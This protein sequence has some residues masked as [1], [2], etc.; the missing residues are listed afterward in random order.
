MRRLQ[1]EGV[2]VTNTAA[3]K[4]DSCGG[5][6]EN[7]IGKVCSKSVHRARASLS[8]CKHRAAGIW[9]TRLVEAPASFTI[10]ACSKGHQIRVP[11]DLAA[12]HISCPKCLE[13]IQWRTPVAPSRFAV[14]RKK[15]SLKSVTVTTIVSIIILLVVC[16]VGQAWLYP[17]DNLTITADT[18]AARALPPVPENDLPVVRAVPRDD[19]APGF[20][21]KA[22][23]NDVPA[24]RAI[25]PVPDNTINAGPPRPTVLEK[26][27]DPPVFKQPAIAMPANGD[28]VPWFQGNPDPSLKITTPDDG[29]RYIKIETWRTGEVVA[30][31]FIRSGRTGT[32]N[33]PPGTYQIKVAKGGDHWFGPM[34]LFGTE[35]ECSVLNDWFEFTETEDKDGTTHSTIWEVT[36]IKQVNGNLKSKPI[37]ITD[38]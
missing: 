7:T 29:N 16:L 32:V 1:T 2:F 17:K 37:P 11:S 38:F 10:I 23:N 35:T 28:V 8:S 30:T 33:L 24:A 18:P 20:I 36:L 21:P 34:Y 25:Q 26:K 9:E 19:S 3:V 22:S 4:C 12:L 31:I 14:W 5:W 6:I 15:V 13:I 27:P